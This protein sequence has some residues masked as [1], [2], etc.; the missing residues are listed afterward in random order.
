MDLR[1]QI[2]KISRRFTELE[3]ALN[4]PR[5]FDHPQRAQELSREYS[6]LKDLAA[7]GQ[8]YLKTLA[9][10]A[11]NRDLIAS[12]PPG[13]ELAQLALEDIA[14]FESDENRL[15]A[16]IQRGLVP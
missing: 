15:A 1:P 7:M 5:A 10:L 14:R 12:E 2:Q 8:T 13:S 4:D 3:S 11:A 9:D 16:E 6:R